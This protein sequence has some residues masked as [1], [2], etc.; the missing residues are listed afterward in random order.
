MLINKNIIVNLNIFK[1]NTFK[2][3][4]IYLNF[5]NNLIIFF[6][7]F[8]NNFFFNNNKTL[9]LNFNFLFFFNLKNN[10]KNYLFY[11]IYF[12]KQNSLLK[13]KYN[14]INSL[15]PI[16]FKTDNI[17]LINKSFSNFKNNYFLKKINIL[18]LSN[19]NFSNTDYY[20]LLNG[21]KKLKKTILNNRNYYMFLNFNNLKNSYKLTKNIKL[22][23]KL[24]IN[25]RLLSF[26]YSLIN[27][28]INSH[29]VKSFNDINFLLSSNLIYVNR[30][31]FN[32]KNVI[33]NLND[34]IEI[35]ISNKFYNYLYYFR[36]ILEKNILK[37]RL[38]IWFKI[39]NKLFLDFNKKI[40][41]NRLFKSIS[42]YNLIFLNYLEV[43]FFSLSIFI[44]NKNLNLFNFNLILKK[45]LVLYLFRLYNWNN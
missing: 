28:L 30:V 38:K 26:E 20:N 35:S 14:Y 16:F 19:F 45:L 7:L 15:N 10:K 8:F 32:K 6:F 36:F 3:I 42:N 12:K 24:R 37:L 17:K 41:V 23:S 31:C 25:N 33:L 5:F 2:Y 13:K 39:K 21:K 1:L 43:D 4:Y 34:L 22:K 18:K 29:L 44:I 9:F 27:I 40:F 11:Y